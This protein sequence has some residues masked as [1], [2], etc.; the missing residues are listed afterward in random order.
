VPEATRDVPGDRKDGFGFG[1]EA[2]VNAPNRFPYLR[3]IGIAVEVAKG[4]IP[5]IVSR[6]KL[7]QEPKDFVR[8]GNQIDR[9]LQADHPIDGSPTALTQ[10]QQPAGQYLFENALGRIPFERD[11]HDLGLMS[12][13]T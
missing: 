10:I 12:L 4:M 13:G 3:T 6:S 5:Q 11:G 9:K 7:V 1:N 2:L 8:V